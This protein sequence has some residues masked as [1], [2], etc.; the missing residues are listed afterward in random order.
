LLFLPLL[1]CFKNFR[2]CI[3]HIPLV[4]LGGKTWV[5]YG[6]H[7]SA[8]D[9]PQLKPGVWSAAGKFAGTTFEN[10][11]LFLYARD[12]SVYLDVELIWNSLRSNR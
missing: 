6:Q 3:R 9:L 1:L 7:S 10:D 8:P 11:A 5:G 12:Y 4:L 2:P